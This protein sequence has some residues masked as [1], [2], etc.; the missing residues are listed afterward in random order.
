MTNPVIADN[1]P[2]PVKL[3]ADKEYHWC[4]CLSVT[5][6]TVGPILHLSHSSLMH[7][8]RPGCACANTPA[9]LP[10]AMVR[11]QG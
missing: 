9:L 4:A 7:P 6:R 8:G 3:D 5:A 2:T 11:M 10:I 1:K